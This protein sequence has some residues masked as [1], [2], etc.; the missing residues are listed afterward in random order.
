M[1]WAPESHLL[2]DGKNYIVGLR[3]IQLHW[4][5]SLYLGW[6]HESYTSDGIP[7]PLTIIIAWYKGEKPVN[8][9]GGNIVTSVN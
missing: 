1:V 3:A 6:C 7:I 4:T 2:H 9:K 5:S 8:F